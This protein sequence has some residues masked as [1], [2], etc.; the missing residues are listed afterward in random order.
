MVQIH[1]EQIIIDNFQIIFKHKKMYQKEII[2][3]KKYQK[4]VQKN[5]ILL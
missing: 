3:M 2:Y 1:K 5:N 4:E